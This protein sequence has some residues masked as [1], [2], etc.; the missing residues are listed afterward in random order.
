MSLKYPVSSDFLINLTKKGLYCPQAEIYIDPHQPVENALITHAH[1]D[2]ARPGHNHYY[3]LNEGKEILKE[4]LKLQSDQI[5]GYP[6]NTTF[7]R[8]GV[9]ISFHAA[10]HVLGSCQI[11]FYDGKKT[12]VVSGDYKREFDPSCSSFQPV[13]C[14][15]FITEAT[16]ALPTYRWPSMDLVMPE[17]FKWW[18]QAIIRRAT[19]LLLCY[20]LGKAQ[21]IM[22]EIKLRSNRSVMLHPAIN[23]L[24]RI[25]ESSGISLCNWRTVQ[26]VTR[27]KILTS[28][29]I[30]APPSVGEKFFKQ[31]D[32]LEIAMASGWMQ[33]RAARKRNKVAGGFVI[34]DHS[35]WCGLIRTIDES[36]AELILPTHG[37]SAILT[38]YLNEEKNIKATALKSYFE[39]NIGISD[40]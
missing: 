13:E 33:T 1:A 22:A 11:K 10:G 36:K 39:S 6:S 15:V 27:K 20:S 23:S 30:I 32:E 7:E 40:Q 24:A 35:D 5:T 26:K 3:T 18:D 38:K 2:H 4:R 37:R 31:F 19:P 28:E 16:F 17:L 8:N 34:S 29:L 12:W 21:R 9:K 25:Y 14:D